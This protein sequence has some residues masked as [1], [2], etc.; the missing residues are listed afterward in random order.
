MI[1]ALRGPGLLW[2]HH[3]SNRTYQSLRFTPFSHRSFGNWPHEVYKKQWEAHP[4]NPPVKK[5]EEVAKSLIKPPKKET[6]LVALPQ[7]I[8]KPL[9]KKD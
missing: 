5:T 1:Q 6:A 3:F 2:T 7:I 4:Q 9:V 8:K